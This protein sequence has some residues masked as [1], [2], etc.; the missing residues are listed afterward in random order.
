[1]IPLGAKADVRLRS[2]ALRDLPPGEYQVELV[3]VSGLTWRAPLE[4]GA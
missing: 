3:D 4:V 1:M 2:A